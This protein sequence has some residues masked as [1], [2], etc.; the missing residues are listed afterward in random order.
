[1]QTI[2]QMHKYKVC[3]SGA[4]LR[5]IADGILLISEQMYYFVLLFNLRFN[6]TE[7]NMFNIKVLWYFVMKWYKDVHLTDTISL[8]Y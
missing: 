7:M 2:M 1:M 6:M 5:N 8:F 3:S 4:K